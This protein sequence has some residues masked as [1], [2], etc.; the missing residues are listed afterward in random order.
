MLKDA[1]NVEQAR[2]WDGADGDH[3]AERED[4]YYWA[5]SRHHRRFMK[6]AAIGDADSVLD[7]GCGT[8]LSTCE[9]ARAAHSGL[10]LGVDLS[11]RMLERARRHAQ[12]QGLENVR[13]EQVDAQVHPFPP[14]AFS[15][16]ISRF[17]C[18]FFSEPVTAFRNIAA[19][20]RPGG[21]LVLISWMPLEENDWLM[22]IREA[23]AA[24][25]ELPGEPPGWPGPF[26]LAEP[27][28]IRETLETAGFVDVVLDQV[29]EPMWFGVSADEAHEF[30]MESGLARGLVGGVDDAMRSR[31]VSGLRRLFATHETPHGVLLDS[32][33]WLTI[34]RRQ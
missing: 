26:G 8:G 28:R 17:G 25:R 31:A 19:T 16:A 29:R 9:A 12:E 23:L 2:S 27:D 34:A 20:L 4:I 6:A 22:K 21:R 7:V 33:A 18:M 24:G 32:A 13:F 10:A 14:G 11:S 1:A 30:W 3:W 5:V 15:V